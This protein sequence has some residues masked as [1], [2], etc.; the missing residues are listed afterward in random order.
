MN[1]LHGVPVNV[2]GVPVTEANDPNFP[3]T[4]VVV[5][6]AAYCPHTN[7][8]PDN[9][10]TLTLKDD[11]QSSRNPLCWTATTEGVNQ[12]FTAAQKLVHLPKR[13]FPRR[14]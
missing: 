7:P 9:T 5:V 4:R 12:S 3:L 13:S 8:T 11:Q 14:M 1:L 6:V 2:F 10:T